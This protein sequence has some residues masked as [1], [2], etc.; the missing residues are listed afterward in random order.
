MIL[1]QP[2]TRSLAALGIDL[3]P[4]GRGEVGA[5]ALCHRD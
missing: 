5:G 1:T 4:Q 2:L 3:S